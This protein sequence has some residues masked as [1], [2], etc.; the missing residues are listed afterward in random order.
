[1]KRGGM[2]LAILGFVLISSQVLAG[3]ND[4]ESFY[5][6]CVDQKIAQCDRNAGWIDSWGENLRGYG[7]LA[8]ERARFYR[9]NKEELI[10]KL[11][12]EQVGRDPQK[13]DY[14]LIKAATIAAQ[15]NRMLAIR[16]QSF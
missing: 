9:E 7:E 10:L 11:T 12:E 3:E 6:T 2:I 4:L 15:Q 14:F 5:R 13:A 1:M 16:G 8:K